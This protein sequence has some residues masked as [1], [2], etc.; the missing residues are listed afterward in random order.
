MVRV[1]IASYP[2]VIPSDAWRGNAKQA[3]ASRTS[4]YSSAAP[5]SALSPGSRA[6]STPG[7]R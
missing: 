7:V 5:L 4:A 1:Q 3:T 2:V 6:K